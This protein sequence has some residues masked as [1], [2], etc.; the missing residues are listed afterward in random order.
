M[1]AAEPD[2]QITFLDF[3]QKS[4]SLFKVWSRKL[5]QTIKKVGHSDLLE[6]I[7]KDTKLLIIV[8]PKRKFS[9]DQFDHL[10][11]LLESELQF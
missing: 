5:R 7:G 3:N 4:E 6:E 1:V 8:N 11:H 9:V 2:S 10:K